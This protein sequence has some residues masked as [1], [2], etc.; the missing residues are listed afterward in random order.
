MKFDTLDLLELFESY[1]RFPYGEEQQIYWYKTSDEKNIILTLDVFSYENKCYI[2]ILSKGQE[3]PI[4]KIEAK[5]VTHLIRK[6]NSLY[7]NMEN[8]EFY[9]LFFKPYIA[10]R[11]NE[12]D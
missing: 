12:E 11:I 9:K 7:I 5:K 2:S 8:N 10:I 6:E 4:F 3:T 1:P